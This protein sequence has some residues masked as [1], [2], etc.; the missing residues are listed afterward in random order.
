MYCNG[1]RVS[2][3]T[4]HYSWLKDQLFPAVP[5]DFMTWH[6]CKSK[7]CVTNKKQKNIHI[8]AKLLC[9]QSCNVKVDFWC[10]QK[11]RL[12]RSHF[13]Q[14]KKC[15]STVWKNFVLRVILTAQISGDSQ[16]LISS[17]I[18]TVKTIWTYVWKNNSHIRQTST[19]L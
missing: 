10:F 9:S 12:L 5:A 18:S 7:Q 4:K 1:R 13:T 2:G 19:I 17:K 15:S 11:G 8:V 16:F 14:L 6:L 3:Q